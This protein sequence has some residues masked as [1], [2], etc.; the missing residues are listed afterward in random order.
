MTS[1][2]MTESEAKLARQP[3]PESEGAHSGLASA[4]SAEAWAAGG[5]GDRQRDGRHHHQGPERDPRE[6]TTPAKPRPTNRR[7]IQPLAKVRRPTGR[8]YRS[9][10][11]FATMRRHRNSRRSTPGVGR[12]AAR[13]PRRCDGR[14]L[15]RTRFSTNHRSSRALFV[16]ETRNPFEGHTSQV[17]EAVPPSGELLMQQSRAIAGALVSYRA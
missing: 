2:S 17:V 1:P 10:A 7:I 5:Q 3:D 14:C 9:D 6:A 13:G 8:H 4:G 12:S 15:N 16:R 11:T